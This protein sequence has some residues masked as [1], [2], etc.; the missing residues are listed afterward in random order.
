[1]SNNYWQ[2]QKNN[3]ALERA[4]HKSGL[5][6]NYTRHHQQSTSEQSTLSQSS[7]TSG[8]PSISP[9]PSAA[10]QPTQPEVQ[11]KPLSLPPYPLCLPQ[12]PQ[13]QG[14]AFIA[15][16]AQMLRR[17]SNKLAA[18]RQTS[19]PP[20]QYEPG[21][22]RPAPSAAPP[23]QKGFIPWRRSHVQRVT[24][25]KKRRLGRQKSIFAGGRRIKRYVLAAIAA[26]LIL[27]VTSSAVY[28]YNFYQS[29]LPHVQNLANMQI[30]QSTHI[31]DRH[32]TLLYTLYANGQWGDGGRSAPISYKY[33]PGVLQDAQIAAEDPTFWI[34]NGIDPQGVLRAFTQFISH[35]GEVQSGGSTMTQQLIKN[36]SQNSQR[37]LQRK[38]NEAA[39]AIGLT[40]EYPKWKIMEMYFNDTPYGAQEKGVE[41][42]V[43]DYF[44][45][46]PQCNAQHECTPGVAFL[47]RDLSKCKDPRD[48]TTCAENP[49][50]ALAR[51]ALLAGIPQNPT[52]FDPSVSA[53]N[54]QNVLSNR[55]PYVLEQ[56][57]ENNMHIYL[58]LGSNGQSKDLGPITRAMVPQ[59]EAIVSKMKIV[60]FRQTM[61]APHFVQW[62]IQSLATSLGQG[63]YDAGLGTLENSGLNIYTTLDL[64][65]E[66]FIEKDVRHNLRDP[67]YQE[68]LGTTGPLNTMYNVNDAAVVVMDA[69]T[70]EVLAMDGS[71]DYNDKRPAVSGQVNAALALRQPG[72]SLKPLIYATAFEKG[73]YP[74]IKL[75]DDKT[76]FPDGSS[77]SL[78]AQ[79]STYIPTD[80][81]RTYHP[82]ISDTTIRTSLAN[83]FNVPAVKALMFAGFDNVVNM[84]RRFG[85]TDL[86]T[87]LAIYNNQHP[88]AP[89]TLDQLFGPSL[90]LG[91]PG[92][93]LLQM[94][95]AYQVFADNGQRVPAHNIL[96]IW[97]NYGHDLYHY[98]PTHPNATSVISPQIAF[99]INSML[100]DNQARHY[101][102]AGVDTLTMGPWQPDRPVAAK[103]G[104]TDRN[105]DNWTLGYTS[106]IVVGAWAGNADGNDPMYGVIGITGAGPIWQDVIEY[107]S[108]RPQLG[109]HSDLNYPTEPFPVPSGVV[110]A[111]VSSTNGLQGSG[112]TDWMISGEQPQQSGQVP[113]QNVPAEPFIGGNPTLPTRPDTNSLPPCPGTEGS[114]SGQAPGMPGMPGMPGNNSGGQFNPNDF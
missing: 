81:G 9:F 24:Y 64:N 70:G 4:A 93:S 79:S 110:Q 10:D 94:V 75:I 61:L 42:A 84:A 65:L 101:E 49:M 104:T 90:A 83:S 68:F 77:Q 2:S 80:Y 29:E 57:I 14:P 23:E 103:T 36:L 96:D 40:Q 41:A 21:T 46:L 60:G 88:G 6:S 59:I 92:I 16:P 114:S 30:P 27:F 15:R 106:S 3:E 72:S 76:Y 39:L 43:E 37:T 112:A 19:A 26:L 89:N 45:L 108:G 71:A 20:D 97:D 74:A 5:L 78:P 105:L 25:L 55:V 111:T 32:G 50:L 86:D 51:A 44:G 34:N 100:S 113:C 22:E 58:G 99:L 62:V 47:D 95:G 69:K 28:A 12:Q 38:T 87:D 35:K 102:F 67:V 1:M 56:M 33:L 73:W 8:P 91:T 54:F 82:Q 85:I 48:K 18:I 31:Y 98:D 107:A 52:H 66:Q 53:E 13:W 11:Q 109:M 63:D 17:W 7:A